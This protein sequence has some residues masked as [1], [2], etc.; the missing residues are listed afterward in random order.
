MT[1]LVI[2]G[3]RNAGAWSRAL[4]RFET[5]RPGWKR[6]STL[7]E[8]GRHLAAIMA[9]GWRPGQTGG[10]FAGSGPSAA[11]A[12]NAACDLADRADAGRGVMR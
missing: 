9:P 6:V 4:T 8:G 5:A 1:A 2:L 12:L 7:G 11:G 10:M 3:R